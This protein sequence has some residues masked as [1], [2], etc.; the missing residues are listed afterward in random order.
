MGFSNAYSISV[1]KILKSSAISIGIPKN[2]LIT[3]S[4]IWKLQKEI[5]K[6]YHCNTKSIIK[7]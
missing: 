1:R 3:I 5:E 4:K 6:Q 7:I 2:I